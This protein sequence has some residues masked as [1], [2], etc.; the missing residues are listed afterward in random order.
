MPNNAKCI[1]CA[2]TTVWICFFE[3]AFVFVYK[4]IIGLTCGSKAMLGSSLYSLTDL[5]SSLLLL[6]SIRVSS[7]PPDSGHP[8]GHGKVEYIVSSAISMIILLGTL[9]LIGF[10]TASL[11]QVY[12]APPPHW[13]GIWASIA[14]ISIAQIVYRMTLCVAKSSNSPAIMSHAKHMRLDTLSNVAV[15]IAIVAAEA[16][17]SE[18]DAV[19]AILESV[20]ILYESAKMLYRSAGPL[21]D[22]SVDGDIM[23]QVREIVASSPNVKRITTIKGISAGRKLNLDIELFLDAQLTIRQ[24]NALAQSVVHTLSRTIPHLGAIHIYYRPFIDELKDLETTRA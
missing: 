10:S 15:I 24:C 17:L 6:V 21:M 16:G 7:K 22:K 5:V 3:C 11:Y 19:I 12:I 2:K 1:R 14:C 23:T 20:H 8:Y 9:L 4:A 18:L 13:I